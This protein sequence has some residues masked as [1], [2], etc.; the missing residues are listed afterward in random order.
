MANY[1][2]TLKLKLGETGRIHIYSNRGDSVEFVWEGTGEQLAWILK[3]SQDSN[4]TRSDIDK[5]IVRIL[6]D[7]G[8]L[9]ELLATEVHRMIDNKD[10]SLQLVVERLSYM[11]TQ[12]TIERRVAA[13][14]RQGNRYRYYVKF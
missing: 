3:K 1:H 11:F 10:I 8:E 5:K 13:L 9:G 4:K 2:E 7:A 12:G 6:E 14:A